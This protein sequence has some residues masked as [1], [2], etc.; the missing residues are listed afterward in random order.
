VNPTPPL[1]SL[2][3]LGVGILLAA[4]PHV[5]RLPW[6]VSALALGALGWRAWAAWRNE[7]MP[8]R[9]LLFA[10]VVFGIGAVFLSYRTLFGRDAGVTMLVLFLALKLLETRTQRDVIIVTFLCYFLSLTNFFYSQTIPTGVLMVVTVLVLTAALVGFSGPTRPVA[11]NFRTAGMLL[12]QGIPVMLILFLLFPRVPGPLW[13][14]PSDAYSGMTGLSESMS[15]GDISSLSQSDAI[16]FRAK[17]DGEPPP[18]KA[19]YWRGPVFWEFDGR[20]W[21]PGNVPS[22]GDPQFDPLGPPVTYAVTVEPHNRPW[23]FALDLP[24]RVPPGAQLTEDFQLHSRRPVRTRLRYDMSSFLEY[25]TAGGSAAALA[26]ARALP[27]GFNPKALALAEQWARDAK[28]D[29]EIVLRAVDFFRRAGFGYTLSPPPLGRDSVDDFI[30]GAKRGFCEHFSSAFAYLM[31][32][33]GVASRVVTGYQGGEINP[34]DG[35]VTVRQADAHAWVEV[36]LAG[37]GWT[38]VDPTAA[39]VPLRIESGLAA[40]VPRGEPLPFLTRSEF[41]WLRTLRFNWEA[42]ANYWNQWVLGYNPERQRGLF[43]R[44]GMPDTNW[45]TMAQI[46]FWAVGA[47][48]VAFAL[49]LL[50]KARPRDAAQAVWLNF[51]VKLARR[52]TARGAAEGPST[53]ADRAALAHPRAAAH[54][55]AIASL[56]IDLRYGPEPDHGGVA[57]LRALV[58]GFRP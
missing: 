42:L 13:G 32:A 11:R 54:I 18:K 35:Y 9:W 14:M 25:R 27:S 22:P 15:P 31:R 36:W 6:W 8:R 10:L 51:C 30:F 58:R 12:A 29:E 37:R 17:F 50:R 3:V 56:Y 28:S 33:A 43:N 57:R 45:Q 23:L 21:R 38:R 2:L 20:S 34:V 55:R 53:F 40:A 26:A 41:T 44:L 4:A 39:A 47:V 19:L 24:G 1:A 5:A 52:G 49:W 7:R 48:I 46:L 16:A